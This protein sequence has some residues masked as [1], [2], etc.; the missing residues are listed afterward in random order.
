MQTW[1]RFA[2]DMMRLNDLQKKLL[3]VLTFVTIACILLAVSGYELIPLLLGSGTASNDSSAA[4]SR[5]TPTVPPTPSP[6]PLPYLPVDPKA[7][8]GIDDGS[9]SLYPG[10]GWT[11]LSYRTCGTKLS[12]HSLDKLVLKYRSQGVRVLLL[13]CQRPGLQLLDVN[14]FSD[15]AHSGADAIACGNEEMKHNTYSTYVDPANFARFYDLC[16]S[17]VHAVNPSIPVLLGSLDPHVYPNDYQL[18]LAQVQYLNAMQTAMNTSV[19]PG[20]HWSWR[21]QILGLIDSWHNGFPSQSVNNLGSLLTFWA[22][23]FGVNLAS[24][25]LGQHL[26]VVE[27]TGCVTGCGLGSNYQVSVAHILT[28]I[29]DVETIKQYHIPFFYFSGEDFFQSGLFWPMGVLTIKG[30]QKGLRQDLTIGARAL[31]LNCSTGQIQVT[32]QEQLLAKLYSGC[33]LPTNYVTTLMN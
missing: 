4:A 18:I 19:H 15:A 28:L 11:R 1:K 10:I 12:G 23:Q 6:T 26:W 21:S 22:Q 27:G 20:G 31:N 14:R 17:T 3:I 30:H 13:V 16:E 5:V 24:G 9:P 32:M 33:S 7:V 29:L 8:L 2:K 25:A